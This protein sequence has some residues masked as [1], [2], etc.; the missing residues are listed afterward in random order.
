MTTNH[1][2]DKQKTAITMITS[3][4]KTRIPAVLLFLFLMAGQMSAA[5]GQ[6]DAGPD[7]T[8]CKGKCVT[9]GGSMNPSWCFHWTPHT[10]L[11]DPYIANPS[12]CPEV[13]TTYSLTVTAPDFSWTSTDQVVVTV[14]VI[15]DIAFSVN[16][17]PSNGSATSQASASSSS[18]GPI[19]WSIEG[20]SR[21]A[22]ISPTGLITAGTQGG[23]ITIR[24]TDSQNPDCYVEGSLCLG[25]GDD[26]C[27]DYSDV[28]K[29][30]GPVSVT[31]PGGV[32]PIGGADAQGYCS[33]SC[34][35][36]IS[37]SM[38]GV[39]QKTY[40]IPGGHGIMER[41]IHQP[42]R[43]QGSNPYMDRDLYCRNLWCD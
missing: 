3:S 12:A 9:I 29:V 33:Y 43:L 34:Q 13:T 19:T 28:T 10:G 8:I 38:E 4:I 35:A 40:S 5:F 14:V 11:S 39:F 42:I 23:N 26:C 17:L 32:S 37:I 21:G 22:S 2:I 1:T 27:A 16:P 18:G 7:T 30:F 36:G 6:A 25:N 15:T 20:E 41:E 31:I 24:A